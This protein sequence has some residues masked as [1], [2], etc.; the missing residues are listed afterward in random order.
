MRVTLINTQGRVDV[1]QKTPSGDVVEVGSFNISVANPSFIAAASDFVAS[2]DLSDTTKDYTRLTDECNALVFQ[3]ATNPDEVRAIMGSEPNIYT[4]LSLLTAVL[5]E[6][7]NIDA[8]A[9]IEQLQKELLVPDMQTI[10][11]EMA[12]S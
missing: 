11:N 3:A 10:A 4:S 9:Q 8:M 1:S 12:R 6:A 7:A 2:L 5:Q